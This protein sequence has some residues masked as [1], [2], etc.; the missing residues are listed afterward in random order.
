MR[1]HGASSDLVLTWQHTS[2][3]RKSGVMVWCVCEART[4][5]AAEDESAI[6]CM[7]RAGCVLSRSD[8]RTAEANKR[9]WYRGCSKD[10]ERQDMDLLVSFNV[11]AGAVVTGSVIALFLLEVH[12]LFTLSWLVKVLFVVDSEL[13]NTVF[14]LGL[15]R[16]GRRAVTFVTFP[17]DVRS[18]K[19][20]LLVYLDVCRLCDSVTPI[21]RREDCTVMVSFGPAGKQSNI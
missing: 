4:V 12:W 15:R 5:E 16:S 17:S 19:V 20:D 14:G 18:G 8:S 21:R 9:G 1:G 13:L 3:W 10:K 6:D 2:G 7:D 11:K